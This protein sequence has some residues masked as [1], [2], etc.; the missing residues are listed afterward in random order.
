MGLRLYDVYFY[1]Q[2]ISQYVLG[3]MQA[4]EAEQRQIDRRAD[5]VEKKLR[6]LMESGKSL[7]TVVRVPIFYQATN[8]SI[9]IYITFLITNAKKTTVL[10]KGEVSDF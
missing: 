2:D 6:R 8:Q 9:Y 5:I 10:F 3:E 4:L 7:S 1:L